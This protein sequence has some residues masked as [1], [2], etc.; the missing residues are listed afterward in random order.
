MANETVLLPTQTQ[1]C[2]MSPGTKKTCTVRSF[3][4]CKRKQL[5]KTD[6]QLQHIFLSPLYPLVRLGLAFHIVK[7]LFK[8]K[9]WTLYWFCSCFLLRGLEGF[10][11][12]PF[13]D[14]MN[15]VELIQL[16]FFMSPLVVNI[17][18]SVKGE[19]LQGFLWVFTVLVLYNGFI[20]DIG[21]QV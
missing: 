21:T 15:L 11:L 4:F 8:R 13:C 5:W 16:S 2:S 3:Y 17:P 20:L 1:K 10:C 18:T 14:K 12:F 19:F 6:K 7:D 9:F